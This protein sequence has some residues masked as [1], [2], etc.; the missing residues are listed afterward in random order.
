MESLASSKQIS[1]KSLR[2]VVVDLKERLVKDEISSYAWLP[3]QSMWADIL[4]KEKKIPPEL[5]DVL[6]ENRMN[7]GETGINKVLA[8]GQEVQVTNIQNRRNYVS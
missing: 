7:L 4:T 8:F 5:E 3:T 1:A 2:N 6:T